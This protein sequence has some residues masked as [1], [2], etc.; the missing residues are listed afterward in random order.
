M[1]LM[2]WWRAASI[3]LAWAAWCAGVWWLR[4]GTTRP[5][6]RPLGWR[7]WEWTGV[8]AM[9]LVGAV[10]LGIARRDGRVIE[11]GDAENLLRHH[12]SWWSW[13]G[14]DAGV[15]SL[16]HDLL[17]GVADVVGGLL[18]IHVVHAALWALFVAIGHQTI[19]TVAGPAL[20]LAVLA[21]ACIDPVLFD[22]FASWR[23]YPTFLV[24][25]ALGTMAAVPNA[26]PTRVPDD[27]L[28]FGALGAA[29]MDYPIVVVLLVAAAAVR[30]WDERRDG[31]T[32]PKVLAATIVLGLPL[33]PLALR[34][35]D[36]P[37]RGADHTLRLDAT[38]W[39]PEP[40]AAA[41]VTVLFA[42]LAR[43]VASARTVT[44]MAVA[45][46]AT[47]LVVVLL[48]WLPDEAKYTVFYRLPVAVVFAAAVVALP[49]A[50]DVRPLAVGAIGL[51]AL[52]A[53]A[54]T[55]EVAVTDTAW[56][57][58][59]LVLLVLQWASLHPRA[60]HALRGWALAAALVAAATPGTHR[61][62]EA[63]QRADRRRAEAAAVLETLDDLDPDA[64]V[65]IVGGRWVPLA[66]QDDAL[67]V[68]GWTGIR[69]V[70]PQ[71]GRLRLAL[72]DDLACVDGPH[73]AVTRDPEH[74]D[75]DCELAAEVIGKGEPWPIWWCAP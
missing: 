31:G 69:R 48:G 39:P 44:A 9:A 35:T 18:L 30:A 56:R 40:A 27:V 20:S 68:N 24:G 32:I 52:V 53:L 12:Q 45:G 6:G 50:R 2:P 3:A 62:R 14:T 71:R 66:K 5:A 74:P 60:P 26:N 42:L 64:V 38:V 70:D 1:G 16:W 75:P 29:A 51:G 37:W 28:L 21:T 63:W 46:H 11:A 67:L 7:W 23:L 41:L 19:R 17:F 22:S 57:A 43:R 55:P 8:A 33:A 49:S 4:R 54:A 34:A 47:L 59:V 13:Y 15:P 25:V 65:C 10:H 73:L 58:A 61:A 36:D 72:E